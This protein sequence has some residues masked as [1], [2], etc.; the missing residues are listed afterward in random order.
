VP[1]H[2]TS[3]VPLFEGSER[4]SCNTH[5]CVCSQLASNSLSHRQ[6]PELLIDPQAD[7]EICCTILGYDGC[8]EQEF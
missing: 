4:E 1:F 7:T 3:T 2:H 8:V 6:F 5:S